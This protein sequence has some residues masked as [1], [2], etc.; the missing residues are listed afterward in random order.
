MV[1]TFNEVWGFFYFYLANI[2]SSAG[3]EDG[4][5]NVEATIRNHSIHPRVLKIKD[6][7]FE[8]NTFYNLCGV[9]RW[10]RHMHTSNDSKNKKLLG[11]TTYREKYLT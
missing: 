2:I 7:F 5:L 11:M 8:L 6:N 9:P 4:I 3:C 1:T 10:Y